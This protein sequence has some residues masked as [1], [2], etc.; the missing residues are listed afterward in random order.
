LVVLGNFVG[1]SS[2]NVELHVEVLHYYERP[3]PDGR[4]PDQQQDVDPWLERLPHQG[5]NFNSRKLAYWPGNG[6]V[7]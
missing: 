7:M 2:K 4:N 3:A 6:K 5:A 1:I